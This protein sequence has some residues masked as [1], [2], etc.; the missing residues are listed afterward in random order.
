VASSF[1]YVQINGGPDTGISHES[2]R[3]IS[4]TH[5]VDREFVRGVDCCCNGPSSASP[6]RPVG[7]Q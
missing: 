2:R 3:D 6:R 1:L 5:G 7:A 4:G